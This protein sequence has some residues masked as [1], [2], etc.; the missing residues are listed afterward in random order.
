MKNNIFDI[1]ELD[2]FAAEL[3]ELGEK[4]L[5]KK[6]NKFM[7]KEGKKL[8][9]V[10]I[11]KAK[12]KT[13]K[14]TGNYYKGIK[15]GKVYKYSGNGGTSIRVYSGKPA[16]HAHLIEYGHRLIQNHKIINVDGRY[17]TVK[18][19]NEGKEIGFVPG[20]YVFEEARNEFKEE[21]YS[22][23]EKFLDEVAKEL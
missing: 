15:E 16:Y 14:K 10:T 5:P 13:N 2:N 6:T 17:I 1:S 8:K 3:L 7:K 21:F 20:L 19:R 18:G 12:S 4:E 9:R 23:I 11:K 22:D